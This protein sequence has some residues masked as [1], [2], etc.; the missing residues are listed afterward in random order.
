MPAFTVSYSSI[1]VNILVYVLFISVGLINYFTI[2]INVVADAIQTKQSLGAIVGVVVL[3]VFVMFVM[4]QRYL[5]IKLVIKRSQKVKDSLYTR[6]YYVFF[7]LL[8]IYFLVSTFRTFIPYGL[9][10]LLPV[11]LIFLLSAYNFKSIRI[12]FVTSS[13]LFAVI[14]SEKNSG[15]EMY[16][17]SILP[18]ENSFFISS[19]LKATNISTQQI[20]NSNKSFEVMAFSDKVILAVEGE[21]VVTFVIC[22]DWNVTT[23]AVTQYLTKTFEKNFSNE[24]HDYKNNSLLNKKEYEKFDVVIESIRNYIPL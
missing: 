21:S 23:Y 19:F 11:S 17:K 16:S 7:F 18:L 2:Q 12:W 8:M 22:S 13:E 10:Y 15:I 20:I 9:F 14:I 5:M 4:Y 6:F 3:L 1:L 24:L